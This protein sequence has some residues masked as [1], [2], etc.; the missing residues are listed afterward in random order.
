M[1][2]PFLFRGPAAPAT[3]A[4]KAAGRPD[5]PETLG[6]KRMVS[7]QLGEIDA[8][9]VNCI[10][11]GGEGSGVVVRVGKYGPYLQEG[12][13]TASLPEDLAPD[14]LT[15]ERALQLLDTPAENKDRELGTDPDGGL[16][17]LVRSGRWGPYVQLGRAEDMGP[18]SKPKTSSLLPGMQPDEVG[19]DDALRLLTLPRTVGRDSATDEDVVVD[20]GRYGPYV[21]RGTTTRSLDSTDQLFSIALPEA[22]EVLSRPPGRQARQAGPP[23]AALGD[24]PV[25]G[26]PILLKEGR[27]GPY[28]TD[29]TTNAS[30]R[31][32]DSVETLTPDR[33]VELLA[34]RRAKAEADA[35]AG[36]VPGRRGRAG[37]AKKA[38]AKKVGAARKAP[39]VKKA[40]AVKKA[41]PARA[42]AA[43]KKSTAKKAS[44]KKATAA[45]R[46]PVAKRGAAA[47]RGPAAKKAL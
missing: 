24:D 9:A 46:G 17:V 45:K 38:S 8:R 28:V 25:S 40:P 36:I 22:L 18:K 4:R 37:G 21:R 41:A 33:A 6:L 14:E 3:G 34:D 47:K 5:E 30:L 43:A 39:G 32:G 12:E 11:I 1:A 2:D 26:K 42:A 7:E 15:L 31:R 23:L 44:A 29:G 16:P 20:N 19:L 10:A 13:R 35:A 27:F